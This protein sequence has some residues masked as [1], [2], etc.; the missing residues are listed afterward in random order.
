MSDP[1][2]WIGTSWKMNK[3]LAEARAFAEGL[4]ASE[5][6]RD[7]RIQRFIVPPSPP[8]ARSRPC[9][10]I[11]ASRSARRTCIGPMKVPGRVRC[12]P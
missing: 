4:I 3:T 11:P 8:C 10:P 7:P 5:A 6:A 9:W 12:R 1:H 2:V